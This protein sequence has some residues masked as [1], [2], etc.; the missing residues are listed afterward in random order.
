MSVLMQISDPHFGTE[1]RP[2]VEALLHLARTQ[3][4]RLVVLSGDITQRARHAQFEA[5]AQFVRRLDLPYLVVPGNH[6]VPLFNL[7]ARLFVPY[8]GYRRC[9]G[10]ELEPVVET[11]DLLVIGLNTTSRW[12]H[13]DGAVT[14]RQIDRSCRL[15]R[16][17]SPQQLRIVVTHQPMHVVRP[18]DEGNL[19]HGARN[20]AVAWADAGADLLLGGHIHL[21][22]VRSLRERFD[23]LRRVVWVVQ[24]GTAL[25]TRTRD[26]VPNSVNIV[27]R[28]PH[29]APGECTVERWDY[30][31]EATAFRLMVTQTL[32]LDRAPVKPDPRG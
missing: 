1:V 16:E 7:A 3:T 4:P 11:P 27:R 21:P 24:A 30:D 2:V 8:R 32:A 12:R 14:A 26:G 18:V 17:A 28:E 25:S 29:E 15:L 22:Y 23:A 20:A 19:L 9:F 6:D 13:T 31:G 10:P 5:A